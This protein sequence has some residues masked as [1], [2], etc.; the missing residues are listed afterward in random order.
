M[1]A[2]T[3]GAGERAA[4]ATR[5]PGSTASPFG[6]LVVPRSGMGT[7]TRL[8]ALFGRGS[9]APGRSDVARICADPTALRVQSPEEI[10]P[11]YGPFPMSRAGD[12]LDATS[13]PPR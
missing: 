11:R 7:P 5:L 10:R 13:T 12:V 9:R 1:G 8:F 2:R 3:T 6:S 4:Y